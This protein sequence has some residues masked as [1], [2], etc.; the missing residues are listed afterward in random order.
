MDHRLL[1]FINDKDYLHVYII[2]TWRLLA[3]IPNNILGGG[4]DVH[5]TS[6]TFST[7][8]KLNRKMNEKLKRSSFIYLFFYL[9]I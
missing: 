2:N 4:G 6:W 7:S 8:W 3:S 9:L 1:K 5:F